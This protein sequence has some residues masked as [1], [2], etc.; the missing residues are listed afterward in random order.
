MDLLS[1][2]WRHLDGRRRVQFRLTLILMFLAALAEVVSLG[3]ALPFLG[4][5]VLCL[6]RVS[7]NK[8]KTICSV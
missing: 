5:F 3:L 4:Q 8:V 1:R 7:N 2:L 6:P